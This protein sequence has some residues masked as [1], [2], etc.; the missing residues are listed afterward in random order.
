MKMA[1]DDYNYITVSF[2]KN[3]SFQFL[4]MKD[5]LPYNKLEIAPPS[6]KTFVG[7]SIQLTIEGTPQRFRKY[8]KSNKED[9][10]VMRVKVKS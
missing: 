8:L 10:A 9:A 2:L 1:G 7:K 5:S 3:G 6:G 4:I